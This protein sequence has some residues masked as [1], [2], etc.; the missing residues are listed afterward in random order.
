L[1]FREESPVPPLD[2]A[3]RNVP[4]PVAR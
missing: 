3:V 1:E 4:E 2:S